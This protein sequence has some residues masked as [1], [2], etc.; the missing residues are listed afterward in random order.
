M[1]EQHHQGRVL[2]PTSFEQPLHRSDLGKGV[3]PI[4]PSLT[5]PK[6]TPSSF[7]VPQLKAGDADLLHTE[8]QAIRDQAYAAGSLPDDIESRELGQLH[9]D[10]RHVGTKREDVA[11]EGKQ[12][13]EGQHDVGSL[14]DKEDKAI[15]HDRLLAADPSD[16]LPYCE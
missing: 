8:D 1:A 13:S 5:D 11:R 15:M 3:P 6:Y 2:K 12:M 4:H 10:V 9:G 14:V 16:G 7:Q